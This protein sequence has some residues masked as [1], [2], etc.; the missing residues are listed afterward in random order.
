MSSPAE[1]SADQLLAA[2]SASDASA[3][4]DAAP[5]KRLLSAIV[6]LLGLAV[7][8]ALPFVLQAASSFFLPILAAVVIGVIMSPLADALCRIGLPNGLA[9]ALAVLALIL[10]M[11]GA[12]LLIVQPALNL[13]DKMPEI[14]KAIGDRAAE[15][16]CGFEVREPSLQSSVR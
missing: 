8:L 14:S 3:L 1:M 6:L 7:M 16:Y 11:V 4:A 12:V 5:T 2:A 13:A 10:I 15:R 9:S